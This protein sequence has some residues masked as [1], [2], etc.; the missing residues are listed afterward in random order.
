MQGSQWDLRVRLLEDGSASPKMQPL[1][2]ASSYSFLRGFQKKCNGAALKGGNVHPTGCPMEGPRNGGLRE[3]LVRANQ[4]WC[5]SCEQ[6]GCQWAPALLC[7]LSLLRVT[8]GWFPH[9]SHLWR[10]GGRTGT[11]V[12]LTDGRDLYVL[13]T[14]G[15]H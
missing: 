9:F 1:V 15:T 3:S 2:I 6:K 7:F 10:H 5:N 8:E 13:H 4:L 14:R 12:P 11:C